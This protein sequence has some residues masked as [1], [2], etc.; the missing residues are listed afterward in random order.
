MKELIVSNEELFTIGIALEKQKKMLDSELSAFGEST[1]A[2]DLTTYRLKCTVSAL[3]KVVRLLS[4]DGN[5]M[6]KDE[7][8]EMLD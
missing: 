5:T 6:T 7:M 1:P 3:G 8:M 2:Y 4:K